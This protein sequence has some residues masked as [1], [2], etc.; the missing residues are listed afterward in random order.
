MATIGAAG[1]SFI[2]EI[3]EKEVLVVG[4]KERVT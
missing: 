2:V 3:L 1:R 4:G